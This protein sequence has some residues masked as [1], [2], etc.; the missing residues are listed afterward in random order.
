MSSTCTRQC[1][2]STQSGSFS[3]ILSTRWPVEFAFCWPL[4]H[5]SVLHSANYKWDCLW[6]S[7]DKQFIMLLIVASISCLQ[8]TPVAIAVDE[9]VP[10]TAN[11]IYLMQYTVTSFSSSVMWIYQ[12]NSSCLSASSKFSSCVHWLFSF[13]RLHSFYLQMTGPSEIN[14]HFK[15]SKTKESFIP[16]IELKLL[17][18]YKRKNLI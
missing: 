7:D 8:H 16:R 12:H 6:P 5:Q 1:I 17:V 3:A 9:D 14:L 13:S 2:C 18:L 15:Y 11:Y 4:L 10:I